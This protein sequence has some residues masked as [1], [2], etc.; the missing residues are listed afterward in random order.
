MPETARL[1][2]TFDPQTIHVGTDPNGLAFDRNRGVLYVADA[3]DGSIFRIEG[4]LQ[5]RIASID[6]GGVVAAT[7]LGGLVVAP[8]GTSYVTRLGHGRAGGIF[9][10][11]PDGRVTAL[12]GL[13]EQHSRL[14]LAY[15]PNEHLLYTTQ[16]RKTIGGPVDGTIE[17]ID[18]S[19]GRVTTLVRGLD[20]PVGLARLGSTLVASDA[21]HRAVYRIELLRGNVFSR[22][23]L[24]SGIDRPD[25]LCACDP[26]S[27]LVACYDSAA[28]RGA[29]RRLWLDGRSSVIT[30]GGW[31]PR[32][33]ATDGE[34]AFV[35]LRRSGRVLVCPLSS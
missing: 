26:H 16:Y 14:G 25:L 32:G 31:E 2:E 5:Q 27:V 6:S 1:H 29:L 4:I 24:A 22:T 10:I 17:E 12:D 18:L 15:D 30:S 9:R 34:R 19:N 11:D 13:S 35:A 7:R 21:K 33:V 8:D 23:T 20:K 3:R 28:R